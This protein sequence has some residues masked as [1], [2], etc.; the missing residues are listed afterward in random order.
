M[1]VGRLRIALGQRERWTMLRNFFRLLV[2]CITG[3]EKYAYALEITLMGSN[4]DGATTG[5]RCRAARRRASERR[6]A[7]N[8]LTPQR[9]ILCEST[10]PRRPAGLFHSE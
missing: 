9:S 4:E 8:A 5:A 10:E 3:L 6:A 7:L 1:D 2:R